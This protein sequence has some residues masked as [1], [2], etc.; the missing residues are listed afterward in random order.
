M[1][2]QPGTFRVSDHRKDI[3]DRVVKE[4]LKRYRRDHRPALTDRPYDTVA[5]DFIPPQLDPNFIEIIEIA[6]HDRRTFGRKPGA[7]KTGSTRGSDIGNMR[8]ARD[9]AARTAV[10]QATLATKRGDIAEA[11]R[12][13]ATAR[14]KPGMKARLKPKKKWPKRPFP[15]GRGFQRQGTGGLMKII[16]IASLLILVPI[17]GSAAD[18]TSQYTCDDV[19][20][21]NEHLTWAQKAKILRGMSFAEIRAARACLA[22]K[23]SEPPVRTVR[24]WQEIC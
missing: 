7:E 6:E 2:L 18:R 3:P 23:H 19:R 16:T 5:G 1:I 14:S 8:V 11:T 10:H 22:G 9:I 4:V 15:K 21:A 17:V 24:C 13:L 20:W 12:I